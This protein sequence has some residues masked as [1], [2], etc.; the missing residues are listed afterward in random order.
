MVCRMNVDR[1]FVADSRKKNARFNIEI[2][3]IIV[4]KLTKFVHIVAEL[5]PYNVLKVALRSSNPLSNARAK[6][7]GRS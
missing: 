1:Q 4:W 3:E 6:S 5:L 2:S 7:K